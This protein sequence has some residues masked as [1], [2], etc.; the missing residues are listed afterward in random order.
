[1]GVREGF[2]VVMAVSVSSPRGEVLNGSR[3]GTEWESGRV[4]L[5]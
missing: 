4:S 5:L 1:M 2:T 3:G